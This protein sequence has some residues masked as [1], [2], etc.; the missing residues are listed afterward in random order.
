M[1]TYMKKLNT[2]ILYYNYLAEKKNY[3]DNI[4]LKYKIKS[5]IRVRHSLFGEFLVTA[6]KYQIFKKKKWYA[7]KKQLKK[8]GKKS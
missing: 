4:L 7:V 1:K 8:K 2:K 6:V 5:V 3:L